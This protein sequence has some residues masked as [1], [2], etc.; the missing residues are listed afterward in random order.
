MAGI[1]ERARAET[2]G[3]I[4]RL[5]HAQLA[6]VGAAGLSLRA[7]ARD[8]GM[9]SSAIYRYVP[10]RDDLLTMLIVEAFDDVGVV[11]ERADAG[12]ADRAD[13]AA[14]WSAVARAVREWALTHQP[15]FEL[16]Y[17]T[18]V[19][20]Y[21]APPDTIAPATRS[22]AVLI[23]LLVEAEAQGRRPLVGP[24]LPAVTTVELTALAERTGITVSPAL[25]AL[26]IAAWGQM[27]GCISIEL[28]GHLH[29]VIDTPSAWFD[30]VM[31][32]AAVTLGLT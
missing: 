27:L 11:A 12:I 29:N 5:A 32:T 4:H 28:F 31:A 2:M 15:Q 20:G 9:V 21:V 6:E 24:A 13:L 18:P 8:L 7:I 14:R 26:G 16:V 10:S 17:G 23:Q 30:A 19:R 1:R 22:T 3:E 25:F